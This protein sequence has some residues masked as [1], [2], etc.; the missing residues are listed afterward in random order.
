M[1]KC[2]TRNLKNAKNSPWLDLVAILTG[3][4][5]CQRKHQMN[6]SGLRNIFGTFA[7]IKRPTFDLTIF[8]DASLEVDEIV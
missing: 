1:A 8:C 4:P 7:P 6:Y 2:I 3:K 5:I